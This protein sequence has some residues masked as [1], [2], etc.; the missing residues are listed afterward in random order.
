MKQQFLV[1]EFAH[2]VPGQVKRIQIT[3]RSLA[4]ALC[5]LLLLSLICFGLF[6]SYVRMSLKASH[7]D[8][9]MADF[10]H[11]R[12]RYQELQSQARQHKEQMASLE[13]LASEVTV[14]YGIKSSPAAA[15]THVFDAPLAPTV[16]ESIE[17]YNFLKSA[18]YSGIY[19]HYAYQWQSHST[20]DLWPIK[21]LLRSAFGGR[22]DPL[23]GEGAFHTGIDLAAPVGTPVHATADGVVVSAG[24]SGDYGKLVVIN[25]GSGL[26]TYYAHLSQCLVVPGQEVRDGQVIALSG[27]TGRVTGPH[28]HYEV[29]VAGTPVNPY[30][31]LPRAPRPRT[32]T[33]QLLHSDLGL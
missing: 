17:E 29:R 26:E 8:A 11:L 21:G 13:S 6:S 1:V 9:L 33:T 30:K 19:H 16:K 7:Y 27:G 18:T 12:A 3:Y 15:S 32:L 25:H 22:T 14:A 5:S 23:S 20:P 10:D 2:S 31:Y 4:Y 28:M 24:W